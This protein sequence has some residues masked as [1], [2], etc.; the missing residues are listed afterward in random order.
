MI[1]RRFC[2]LAPLLALLA[3][4]PAQQSSSRRHDRSILDDL[5]DDERDN[6]GDDDS[7]SSA[8][9][10][11]STVSVS[12]QELPDVVRERN[13]SGIP[14]Q[15]VDRLRQI[16]CEGRAGEPVIFYRLIVSTHW[17]YYWLCSDTRPR[18]ASSRYG[19]QNIRRWLKGFKREATLKSQACQAAG[20]SPVLR[21]IHE[22]GVRATAY[23]DGRIV[24]RFPDGGQTIK[25]YSSQGYG[26]GGGGGYGGGGTGSA[27]T[28]PPCPACPQTG[29][30][31]GNDCPPPRPC[32][33][34][35]ACPV[36]P[37]PKPCDCK[38]QMTEAGKKGFWQGV[39]KAC[40]RICQMIY[41]E[42][43]R[44]DPKTAMCH[45]LSEYCA[46]HCSKP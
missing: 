19:A 3:A 42:C 10:D 16:L 40:D 36:C 21:G 22:S 12:F 1:S 29:A 41:G 9:D 44:I 31:G 13:D 46:T 34:P 37:P 27:S 38:P 15:N 28:C 25:S 4:C 20:A 32:P 7:A 11:D 33:P 2:W 6:T 39:K 30:V 43:R 24:L 8:G 5:R 26:G 45:M 23:C 35:R 18:R 14:R 17:H